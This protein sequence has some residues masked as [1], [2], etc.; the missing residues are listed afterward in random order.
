MEAME[1]ESSLIVLDSGSSTEVDEDDDDEGDQR[2][3]AA[4]RSPPRLPATWA[5]SQRAVGSAAR[6]GPMRRRL[7]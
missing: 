7:R 6:G 5:F 1:V 3:Q 2:E 4:A